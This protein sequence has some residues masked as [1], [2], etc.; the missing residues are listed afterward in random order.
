MLRSSRTVVIS[1]LVSTLLACGGN[2]EETDSFPLNIP[3]DLRVSRVETISSFGVQSSV[4][5]A[6]DEQGRLQTVTR[7]EEEVM[8]VTQSYMYDEEGRLTVRIDDV[9]APTGRDTFREFIYDGNRPTGYIEQGLVNDQISNVEYQ[10]SGDQID[11][12]IVSNFDEFSSAPLGAVVETGTYVLSDLGLVSSLTN[13]SMTFIPGFPQQQSD[14][15]F[16]TNE[17]GQRITDETVMADNPL[18]LSSVWEYE[19][20]P[21]IEVSLGT[22]YQWVCVQNSL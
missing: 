14:T 13:I 18:V 6:Y 10:Y 4:T 2:S 3:G 7:F 22:V 17:L 15:I 12:F 8:T 20:A 16:V 9:T 5:Y 11:G 1:I 19:E 21:C